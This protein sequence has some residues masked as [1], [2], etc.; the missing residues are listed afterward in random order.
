MQTRRSAILVAAVALVAATA[1]QAAAAP[2][3][4]GRRA[5]IVGSARNDRIEGTAGDDVIVGLNGRDRIFARGGNDLVCGGKADNNDTEAN[6]GDYLFGGRGDDKIDS[7][8]GDDQTHG[9][10]GDDLLLGAAPA[11]AFGDYL[12]GGGGDD[13]IVGTR[14]QD[15]ISPGPGR[16]S[17]DGKASA[18]WDEVDY[19]RSRRPVEVDLAAGVARGEGRDLLVGVEGVVGSPHADV[20]RG[21]DGSNR[22]A[23]GTGDDRI[24]GGAG[25]DYL[26]DTIFAPDV[27]T[28]PGDDVLD[29]GPGA[30]GLTLAGGR[31]V[32]DGGADVDDFVSLGGRR[33]ELRG[34]DGEDE[35][36]TFYAG[37]I[38]LDLGTGEGTIGRNGTLAVSSIDHVSASRQDDIIRG[39]DGVNWI[40]GGAG[41]DELDGAGGHDVLYHANLSGCFDCDPVM[42][43]PI[44]VDLDAGTVRGHGD[45]TV[46]GFERVVATDAD[47]VL[48]GSDAAERLEARAGDD[49][50]E[51]RAGDDELDGGPGSD[52][53]SGGAGSDRC[54][55]IEQ[56]E[57]CEA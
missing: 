52:S 54:T 1:S 56:A 12:W 2:E 42:F 47:D 57:D 13:R 39:D 3:C 22:L 31:D 23:G 27:R 25:V 46:A 4:F 20:I 44:V 43:E 16:D 34:G 9:G 41:D 24:E 30:D 15:T 33:Q 53:G 35:I 51:G 55:S 11:Q 6:L 45:D 36:V 5:T 38:V 14:Y 18:I 48:R 40:F 50:L 49:E 28:Y 26:A 8:P 37:P 19:T 29:G 21:D 7:G 32:A 10:P 17:V